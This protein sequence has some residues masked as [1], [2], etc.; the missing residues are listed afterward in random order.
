[1]AS[2]CKRRVSRKSSLG[3]ASDRADSPV[4]RVATTPERV[5]KAARFQQ[6]SPSVENIETSPDPRVAARRSPV[7]AAA[8]T[9]RR[10][11]AKTRLDGSAQASPGST[12]AVPEPFVAVAQSACTEEPRASASVGAG[13][14]GR[15]SLLKRRSG[16]AMLEDPGLRRRFVRF[17]TD[18]SGDV[19]IG[20]DG[21]G[22]GVH[23]A[24]ARAAA[25]SGVI[26]SGFGSSRVEDVAGD[27]RQRVAAG[28]LRGDQRR[29]DGTR[30][31]MTTFGG[32]DL[33]RSEGGAWHA[34]RQ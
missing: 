16:A 34:R 26:V 19:D 27:E 12:R 29:N 13:V 23:V 20:R 2:P 15:Q 25:R 3:G 1:M 33:D 6:D 14:R 17:G 11:R 7:V 18:D 9:P 30:G 28:A 24:P 5:A 21:D 31:R 8:S 22:C 10:L 32:E 4:I